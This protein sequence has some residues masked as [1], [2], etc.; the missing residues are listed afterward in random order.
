MTET[1]PTPDPLD[2]D[3]TPEPEPKK[4]PIATT[5]DIVVV[6]LLIVAG[7]GFWLWYRG[8]G[9]KSHLHFQTADSLYAAGRFP[10]A[11]AEYRKLRDSVKVATKSEDSLLYRRIDTLSD[12]EEHARIL[13]NGAQLAIASGDTA[14][15]AK[16]H[17]ALLSD[18][19]G[20]IAD[21]T[22]A[23]L[24]KALGKP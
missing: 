16:A 7:L 24:S 11:L 14:L 12:L 10:Q 13:S 21:T 2:D 20:F 4:E 15:M 9:D 6:L 1:T 23:A 18:K 22:L 5:T 8:E 3:F 19:S 17:A